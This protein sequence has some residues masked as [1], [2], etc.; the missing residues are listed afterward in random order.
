LRAFETK[1]KKPSRLFPQIPIATLKAVNELV[2]SIAGSLQAAGA[3]TAFQRTAK[4]KD[5]PVAA[6]S[7]NTIKAEI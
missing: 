5:V 2:Q 4:V 6:A 3:G 7:G 1:D